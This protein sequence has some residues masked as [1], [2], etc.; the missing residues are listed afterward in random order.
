ML[1]LHIGSCGHFFFP[2]STSD[3]LG[4]IIHF[5]KNW[6]IISTCT[7]LLQCHIIIPPSRAL[8]T[9]IAINTLLNSTYS[10][11]SKTHISSTLHKILH[12][13]ICNRSAGLLVPNT[14]LTVLYLP[15]STTHLHLI[16]TIQPQPQVLASSSNN[17]FQHHL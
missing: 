13:H 1:V 15:L 10:L 4:Y 6:S 5:N 9:I 2:L 11:K 3:L 7:L 12:N 17:L 8:G 16:D 14:L